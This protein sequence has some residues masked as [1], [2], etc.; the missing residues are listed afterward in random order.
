MGAHEKNANL[1]TQLI[2]RQN[3]ETTHRLAEPK[4]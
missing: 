4:I 3:H 1:L 2:A